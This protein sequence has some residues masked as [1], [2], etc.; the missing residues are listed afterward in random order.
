M[1]L[2]LLHQ[3]TYPA[4]TESY[5]SMHVQLEA[6]VAVGYVHSSDALCA[7]FELLRMLDRLYHL[8]VLLA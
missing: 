5:R 2:L 4:V 3:H 7:D 1:T 6:G 8:F